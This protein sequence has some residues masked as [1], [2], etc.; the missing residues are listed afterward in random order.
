MGASAVSRPSASAKAAAKS[1][2]PALARV[3][4]TA[5]SKA[6]ASALADSST[7][8][9]GPTSITL[10]MPPAGSSRRTWT[11]R[12][13]ASA[14]RSGWPSSASIE[15]EPSMRNTVCSASG[16]AST[17]TGS[18]MATVSRPT[19]S[20]CSSR[21]QDGRSMRNGRADVTGRSTARHNSVELTTRGGRLGLSTWSSTTGPASSAHHSPAGLANST[22][23]GPVSPRHPG[24][25]GRRVGERHLKTP[26]WSQ[27]PSST[28]RGDG[29][30]DERHLKTPAWSQPLSS[31]ASRSSPARVRV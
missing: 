22:G 9:C 28:G 16:V 25:S 18:A 17:R 10:A 20:S 1:A 21:S 24:R 14:I 7:R 5:S 2:R 15:P 12:A 11:A 8:G 23:S 4:A 27:P 6:P 3:A 30:S 26:A 19:A 29:D 31:T 13:L